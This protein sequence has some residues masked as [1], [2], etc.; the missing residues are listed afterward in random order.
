LWVKKS[1]AF[2]SSSENLCTILPSRFV[3]RCASFH[4]FLG[5]FDFIFS[6]CWSSLL[7]AFPILLHHSFSF[8]Y[9]FPFLYVFPSFLQRLFHSLSFFPP[10]YVVFCWFSQFPLSSPLSLAVPQPLCF[11][12]FL[13]TESPPVTPVVVPLYYFCIL[14]EGCVPFPPSTLLPLPPNCGFFEHCLFF[15]LYLP[16]LLP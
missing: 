13:V 3:L 2:F 1:L 5:P 11:Y 6:L 12:F 15:F 10:R 8:N 4:F 16:S 9:L 7:F 14:S